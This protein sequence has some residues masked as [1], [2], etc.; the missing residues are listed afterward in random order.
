MA[1]GYSG[2]P[3]TGDKTMTRIYL[4]SAGASSWRDLLADPELHWKRGASAT[5]L[6]VSSELAAATDRGL[7]PEVAEVLTMTPLGVLD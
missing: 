2:P 4:P 1:T 5:E 6:A 3:Q 7:P